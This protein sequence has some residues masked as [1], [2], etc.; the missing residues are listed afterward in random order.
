MDITPSRGVKEFRE[1]VGVIWRHKW[2]VLL[3]V[4]IITTVATGA[5]ILFSTK[6]Y[7]SSTEI[8][9]Q[10]S[11]LDR[12]LMGS[13][14]FQNPGDQPERYLATA[15]ELVVSQPVNTTVSKALGNRLAGRDPAS[16]VS[17]SVV[18]Q[19]DILKITATDHDPQLASDVANS[20]AN[21]YIAWRQQTDNS[22]LQQAEVPIQAQLSNMTPDQQQGSTYNSLNNKLQT[23]KMLQTIQTGNLQI[24]NKAVPAASPSS[25]RPM[26]I[27]LLAFFSSLIF[28]FGAVFTVEMT[29]KRIRSSDEITSRVDKPILASI[30][31]LRSADRELETLSNPAGPASEAYRILKTNLSYMEPDNEI[32]SIMISS[33]EPNDGK[34]TTIANLAVTLARGGKKIIVIEGDLRRPTLADYLDLSNSIG[35][36]NVI[37]GISNLRESLQMIEARELSNQITNDNFD[38]DQ[39]FAQLNGTKPIYCVTSGPIPPNPGEMVASEKMSAII[40]EAAGHADL[41][42]VDAPPLLA[43]ADATSIASKVDGAILV[44]K[45]NSTAKKSL[46]VI[47]DFISTVPCK[48]LGVV[49]TN[50]PGFNSYKKGNG[51]YDVYNY[52]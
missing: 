35:V 3:S 32:K 39:L 29:D 36:T 49:V 42:L 22:I 41:V 13:Q 17:V 14:M 30:P 25:P 33:S 9:Q 28:A 50:A 38:N 45:L 18:S 52:R 24:V 47:D 48:V 51:Y 21:N 44:V 10:D 27:G 23:L 11:G 19:A 12:A 16:M 31:F 4:V 7:Q 5:T 15:A 26:R 37:S 34:S 1:Q 40:D 6:Q 43:A 8:L 2:L 46:N 20:Y